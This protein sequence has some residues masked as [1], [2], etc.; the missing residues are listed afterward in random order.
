MIKK[1]KIPEYV[2]LKY[3]ENKMLRS[4]SRV[5]GLINIHIKDSE[6]R[7]LGENIYTKINIPEENNSAVDGYALNNNLNNNNKI[8][9]IGESKPGKPFLKK[10]GKN[11]AIRIFTGSYLL[12]LNNLNTV[13]MEEDCIEKNKFIKFKKKIKTGSN[14]RLKGEDI[15]SDTIIF[16]K[17]R[18][19]RFSDI[20]QILS[21]GIMKIKVYKK[22]IVGLFSTGDEIAK[23]YT[24]KKNFQIYD[25]NKYLLISLFSKVGCEVIDLGIIEDDLEKTKKLILKSKRYDL[26]VTSGGISKSS[27]DNVSKIMLTYGDLLFWRIKIK[28]GRPF[29]FG[30][31]K[32]SFFIGF[33]GNPVAA[34]VTFLMLVTTFIKKLSGNV[35][36]SNE[37]DYLK[38]DFS[39]KKKKNRV[40]WLRGNFISK[41]KKKIVRKFHT[42]GSG[43]IS[44]LSKSNGII[45]IDE[46]V[47]KINRG[48][49]LKFYRYQDLLN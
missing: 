17:G 26:I 48:N 24:K 38:C 7:I 32:G 29:A 18:K 28:P 19:L 15:K 30:K 31:I 5:P 40:E 35:N 12:T 16:K 6:G 10:V 25:V 47:E 20:A 46:E 36:Y 33:P 43:I 13:Y 4:I 23:L 1:K 11:Q 45:Q 42:T 22:P 27:T 34:V 8:K 37:P 49:I 9:I 41:N 14:I 39:M 2:S 21:L 44:S 3:A